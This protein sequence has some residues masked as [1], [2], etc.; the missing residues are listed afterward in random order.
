MSNFASGLAAIRQRMVDNYM[1]GFRRAI[2]K[3]KPEMMCPGGSY[4]RGYEAGKAALTIAEHQARNYADETLSR[5][6]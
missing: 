4:M 6:R 3:G 5:R 1:R 2:H